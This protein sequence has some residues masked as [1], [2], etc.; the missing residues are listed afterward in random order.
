MTINWL[1]F[2]SF[3]TLFL[4]SFLNTWGSNRK[5]LLDELDRTIDMRPELMLRKERGITQIKQELAHSRKDDLA[6]RSGRNIQHLI[7]TQLLIM[8]NRCISW[9]HR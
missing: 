1:R 8:P 3:L 5:E 4:L 2:F 6:S 7:P 9:Q